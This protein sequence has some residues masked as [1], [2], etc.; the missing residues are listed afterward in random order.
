MV[1]E[2]LLQDF[3]DLKNCDDKTRKLVLNFS[4]HLAEGNMDLAYRN[5]RSIQSPAIWTNLAKMCVKTSRLDVAKVCMGHL[6]K[7]R[8]VRAIRQAMEDDDLEHEAKLAVL[9]IELG[10][11]DKAKELYISCGRVD[12]LNKLMQSCGRLDEVSYGKLLYI[13]FIFIYLIRP[14]K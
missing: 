3:M 9:A 12:L 14:S 7:A 2:T 6:Q 11:I 1:K 5:I 10:I 4:L 13:N 8:S